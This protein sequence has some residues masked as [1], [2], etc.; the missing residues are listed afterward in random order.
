[1]SPAHRIKGSTHNPVFIIYLPGLK[2][3]P[4]APLGGFKA[5]NSQFDTRHVSIRLSLKGMCEG[6]SYG[7]AG[8]GAG[9]CAGKRV[10]VAAGF[11]RHPSS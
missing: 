9:F 2:P 10:T 5:S 1:M 3:S 7:D 4:L 6:V 11:A 8:E